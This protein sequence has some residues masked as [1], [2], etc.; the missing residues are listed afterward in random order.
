MSTG[1]LHPL[2]VRY[3]DTDA[4]GHVFFANY[5]TYFDE[6]LTHYL[7]AIGCPYA[8]LSALGV[9]LVYARSQCSH[10]G[11]AQFGDRLDIA[12]ATVR[13]GNTSITTALQARRG[14]EVLAEGELVSVCISKTRRTPVRVPDILR[15]A[16][17]RSAGDAS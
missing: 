5:L 4:Q 9:E 17:A 7:D 11:S 16:V 3:A 13:I 10:Q 1:F 12:V 6:G 8:A 15:A 2:S 14:S